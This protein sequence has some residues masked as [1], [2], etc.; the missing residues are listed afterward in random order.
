M[1]D[2]TTDT[3]PQPE[4]TSNP[5]EAIME[6]KKPKIKTDPSTFRTPAVAQHDT[7]AS[8]GFLSTLKVSTYDGVFGLVRIMCPST[9]ENGGEIF[10]CSV[11]FCSVFP[12]K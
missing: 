6:E 1:G 8:S 4:I 11:S 2:T 3:A 7:S 10:C 12:L 5:V 9:L